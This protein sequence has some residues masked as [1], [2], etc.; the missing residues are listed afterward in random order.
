MMIYNGDLVLVICV[1]LLVALLTGITLRKL[2][3][4]PRD[5][6]EA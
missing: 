2:T 6:D 3:R 1:L 4:E 5:P